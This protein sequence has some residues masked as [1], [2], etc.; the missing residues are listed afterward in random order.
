MLGK[1]AKTA[2]GGEQVPSRPTWRVV[3]LKVVGRSCMYRIGS[4]DQEVC[5]IHF[6]GL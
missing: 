2:G 4:K 3:G 6:S 1:V 5:P